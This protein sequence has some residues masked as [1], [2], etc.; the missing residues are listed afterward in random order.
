MRR[1][2]DRPR[3]GRCEASLRPATSRWQRVRAVPVL[4][5]FGLLIP[6]AACSDPTVDFCGNLRSNYQLTELVEAIRIRDQKAIEAKLKDLRKLQ[7]LAP[8]EIF[9]DLRLL[10]DTL[11]TAIKALL[12]FDEL[13]GHSAPVDLAALNDKLTEIK[14]PAQNIAEY[15]AKNCGTNLEGS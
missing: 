13:E 8:A 5:T 12:K 14:D 2:L 6:S 4:C 7:D 9:D 11:S 1:L 15:A 3:H 10:I